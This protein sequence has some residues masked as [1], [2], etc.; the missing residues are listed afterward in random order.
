MKAIKGGLISEDF[1]F[2]LTNP[3]LFNL[4]SEKVGYSSDLKK[5][6]D[7]TKL[8]IPFE[9]KPPLPISIE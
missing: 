2:G 1:L 5:N 3:K 7:G 6:E 4:Q 9:I 8:K